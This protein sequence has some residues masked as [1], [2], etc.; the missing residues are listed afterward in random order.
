MG[1][2]LTMLTIKL[3]RGN[4]CQFGGMRQRTGILLPPISSKVNILTHARV[5][6][7]NFLFDEANRD[8][9]H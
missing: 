7:T 8:D 5:E 1:T 3:N 4:K 2:L 6:H 9:L